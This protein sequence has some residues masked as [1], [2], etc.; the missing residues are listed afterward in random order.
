[1]KGGIAYVSTVLIA[2]TPAAAEPNTLTAEEKASGFELI[3]DGKSLEG[4]R[5]YKQ[6]SP[7]PKW[8]VRDGA[9]ML[10]KKGGGNLMTAAQ[11]GDFEFRF[12]FRIAAHGNS[13]IMWRVS[14]MEKHPFITGP[15]YQILDSHSKTGYPREIA[16]GN[17]S[18]GLYGL[19]PAK[20]EYFRPVGGWNTGS[21]RAEGTK[22]TL[23]LNGHVTADIDTNSAHWK[24]LLAKSKFAGWPRFNKEPKGHIVF[25]DHNDV[26][27][28]RTLRIREL[29]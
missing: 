28:F 12:E 24:E 4:F 11:Y 5:N 3:F 22:I 15:E 2:A 29:K 6:E 7:N 27:E 9:I 21:I 16:A 13:G 17:L 19:I 20:P 10:T 23:V 8:Q 18:G 1:M 26:V 14:E 25:Q